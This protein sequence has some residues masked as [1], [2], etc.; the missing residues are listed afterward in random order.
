MLA[1]KLLQVAIWMLRGRET[2]AGCCCALLDDHIAP[3]L[4]SCALLC[5]PPPA[6]PDDTSGPALFVAGCC[7]GYR[8]SRQLGQLT[9]IGL[10]TRRVSQRPL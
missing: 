6:R 7:V 4:L 1:V 5:P 10:G 8:P 2:T 9:G 3:Q